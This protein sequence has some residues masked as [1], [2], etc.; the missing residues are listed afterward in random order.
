M[1]PPGIQTIEIGLTRT[2]PAT[3]EEVYDLWLAANSPGSPWYGGSHR[4]VQP[5]VDG[6]FCLTVQHEGSDYAHYGRFLALE[7]PRRIGHTWIS[8][9]TQGLESVVTLTFEAQEQQTLV[10]L[11]H[12]GVPDDKVGRQHEQ[13]WAFVLDAMADRLSELNKRA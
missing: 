5:V 9:A 8:R 3:P 13:G 6:L 2:M 10:H 4:I 11:Q 12:A 7:R 1:M